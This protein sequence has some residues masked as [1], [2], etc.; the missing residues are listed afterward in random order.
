VLERASA[1]LADVVTKG[2]AA[3]MNLHNQ[4]PKAPTGS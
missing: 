1:A 3:A 4:R 2:P